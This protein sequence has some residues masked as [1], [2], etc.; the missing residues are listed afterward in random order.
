MSNLTVLDDPLRREMDDVAY[1]I[2]CA[3]AAGRKPADEYVE[4]F[5]RLRDK[6]L[7]E[8]HAEDPAALSGKTTTTTRGTA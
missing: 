4:R 1:I 2:A 8:D 6:W 3:I 7:A 5:A